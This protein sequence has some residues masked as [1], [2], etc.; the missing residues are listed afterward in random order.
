[1]LMNANTL[2]R[3][4][5]GV[6]SCVADVRST[7][8]IEFENPAATKRRTPGAKLSAKGKAMRQRVEANPQNEN[9]ADK[10]EAGLHVPAQVEGSEQDSPERVPDDAS[11][12]TAYRTRPPTS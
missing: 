11:S 9:T 4:L 6:A 12:S 8:T 1:M 5:S 2:L 3:A 10:G 7:L